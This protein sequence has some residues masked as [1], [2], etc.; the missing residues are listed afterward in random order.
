MKIRFV[1]FLCLCVVTA[2][3]QRVEWG[4]KAGLQLSQFKG[5]DFL[6]RRTASS[7]SNLETIRSS[8]KMTFGYAIGGYVRTLED[9]FLQ[10][11]LLLSVKGGEL[12]SSNSSNLTNLQYGQI[13]IPLSIGYQ[14][15]RFEIS[16]GPML[17][18]KAF[19]DGNLKEFLSQYSNSPLTFSP[20]RPFTLGYQGGV[21][22]KANKLKLGLR[23]LASIQGVSDMYIAY[24]VP[25]DS[26]LRDS[27]FFQKFGVL[28]LTAAYQLSK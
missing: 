14:K 25:G 8:G 27:R 20:Y 6:A 7:S 21:G 1:C 28:Q 17:S 9:V 23:Y 3:A 24:N 4:L 16:A 26:Q 5:E 19:D 13:D 18:F 12:E 22:F 11:E 10:G 15:N 2:N